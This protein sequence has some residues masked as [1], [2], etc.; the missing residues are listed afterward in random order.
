[1][2]ARHGLKNALGSIDIARDASEIQQQ[3][4][5]AQRAEGKD[6][7][8]RD[9]KRLS[10]GRMPQPTR[11]RFMA[12]WYYREEW[13]ISQPDDLTYDGSF[14]FFFARGLG[15]D[16]RRPPFSFVMRQL[17]EPIEAIE[18]IDERRS[19]S[20]GFGQIIMHPVIARVDIDSSRWRRFVEINILQRAEGLD[21]LISGQLI[22]VP[23]AAERADEG[24][25]V[26]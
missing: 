4:R 12:L 14:C 20:D 9:E 11:E 2:A 3:G 25:G 17:P 13:R 6:Q 23:A 19:R 10:D 15:E 5:Q 16:V 8:E 7:P 22:A 24:D 1:M 21:L 18:K 26:L